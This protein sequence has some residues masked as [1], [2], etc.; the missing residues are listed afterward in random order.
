LNVAIARSW[1]RLYVAAAAFAR[2][3]TDA[4]LAPA[5]A[6]TAAVRTPQ[7]KA[8]EPRRAFISRSYAV[9]PPCARLCVLHTIP[10]AYGQDGHSPRRRRCAGGCARPRSPSRRAWLL[11]EIRVF[12]RSQ[13]DRHSIRDYRP[14]VPAVWLHADDDHA[15]AAGLSRPADP[16]DRH[17]AWAG[18]R[19]DG[20][21]AP[22]V[23]QPAG[24]DARHH[25]GV[26]GRRAARRRR[27]RQL[28]HAASDRRARHGV[29]Q[30]Q[31]VE[32][33]G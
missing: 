21:R 1:S 3:A 4:G 15:V 18:A 33:L 30:A 12:G 9:A 17:V 27:L 22:R 28:R 29:P 16:A 23:L 13:G 6:A 26:H 24:R 19:A 31:H 2:S 32:L 11:A 14:A 25:H 20:H 8:R 7:T 5:G 10:L